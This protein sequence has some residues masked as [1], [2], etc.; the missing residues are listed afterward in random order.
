MNSLRTHETANSICPVLFC[1]FYTVCVSYTIYVCM[2]LHTFRYGPI[3]LFYAGVSSAINSVMGDAMLFGCFSLAFRSLVYAIRSVIVAYNKREL[4]QVK[5]FCSG[6]F[7]FVHS[8]LKNVFLFHSLAP[9]LGGSHVLRIV[10]TQ[11]HMY[12]N[13]HRQRGGKGWL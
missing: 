11:S 13:R 8:I 4:A 3:E 7:L 5:L 12:A 9:N 1:F 10:C 2:L 6:L